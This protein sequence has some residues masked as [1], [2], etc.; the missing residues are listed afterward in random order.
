MSP[1]LGDIPK[2]HTVNLPCVI[3]IKL[4]HGNILI[5]QI[6]AVGSMLRGKATSLSA[7]RGV[8]TGLQFTPT[9]WTES[10]LIG[11]FKKED[12][13]TEG[14]YRLRPKNWH[15]ENNI[16]SIKDPTAWQN[17]PLLPQ[18]GQVVTPADIRR[19]WEGGINFVTELRDADDKCIRPGMRSPQIGALHA[20]ASHRTVSE[21]PAII[22]MPTGTGK[23]EVM[24]ACTVMLNPKRLL[25]LVPSDALRTQ[26]FNKFT[27]FGRLREFGVISSEVMNPVVALVKG[28]IRNAAELKFLESANVVVSTV[29]SL[30]GMTAIIRE[31][32]IK[33]FDHVFFDEAHHVPSNTWNNLYEDFHD[34]RIMQFTATPFRE[35]G[36]RI[37]GKIIY[38]F[39]LRMAQE[40]KY[41]RRINFKEVY[42]PDSERSDEALAEKAVEALREDISNGYQHILLA[43]TD[44]KQK[45]E[46]IVKIYQRLCP[47]F[48][49]IAIY[50]QKPG[51]AAMIREIR[52]LKHNV[53]VCVD[54][55]GEGFDL[56]NLKIAALHVP[57]S[58]LAITLQFCGRFTRDA[59][60]IGNATLVANIADARVSE[61]IEELY[62]EDSDWNELIPA[63]SAKAIE[64]QVNFSDFLE[65]MERSDKGELFDL[66]VL[67]PKTST[68][69]F[70]VKSFRPHHFRKGLTKCS[71]VTRQ[72][73]SKNKN[74]LVFITRSRIPIDWAEVKAA[75]DI[76]WDLYVLYWNESLGVLS[77]NSSVKGAFH[78][79]LAK[80]VS[81]DG[82]QLISGE[83]VFRALSGIQ[84]LVFHNAGLYRQGTKL[85]FRMYVGLD[86]GEAISPAQQIG[87]V[88]SN[89]FGVGYENG[90]RVSIG[91]SRN[92]RVWAMSSSSIPDW[93]QW[94]ENIARKITDDAI[95]TNAFLASTLI[96]QEISSLP[97]KVYFAIVFPEC[98]YAADVEDFT[99]RI[100]SERIN[101]CDLSSVA[102]KKQNPTSALWEVECLGRSNS[103]EFLLKWGPEPGAFRVC[104]TRGDTLEIRKGREVVSLAAFFE[105][106]PPTI[107]AVDGSE[108]RG[109]Q[110]LENR[111][112]GQKVF[113]VQSITVC[114]WSGVNI[115][116]ES[117]WKDGKIR[118]NSIQAFWIERLR[119]D[120]P[121]FIF[122]DD[123]AGEA[124][125]VITLDES[126]GVLSVHLYHCKFS[127]G[128]EAGARVKDCYEVCGQ[129]VKSARWVNNYLRLLDHIQK[130]ESKAS[131][132]SR[133]SRFEHGSCREF[134]NFARQAKR[135]RADFRISIVQPGISR[136]GVTP[137]ISSILGA[138]DTFI[139]DFTGH[140]MGVF[141]SA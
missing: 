118:R 54:M 97:D 60:A 45:A 42:E 88:K 40:Q 115:Q 99:I 17:H 101:F 68:V 83:P 46:E 20:I 134:T 14:R 27:S 19:S 24:L 140:E 3:G 119:L 62:A 64:S 138:A 98:F 126:A 33:L 36:K 82:A 43:R 124:A 111:G 21:K 91:A 28:H 37:P 96:P 135:M 4:Q 6:L 132:G 51:R 25:V 31:A 61:S 65:A 12:L 29:A 63:L 136:S 104:Q 110:L 30:V 59:P 125:D 39:P 129:A 41:F 78:Q 131:R 90:R 44:T 121:L 47:E 71:E 38:N 80:A 77:I 94:C 112:I 16:L 87:N 123:D 23:T 66:N 18:S 100:A 139:R 10:I 141:G 74:L 106:N 76:Q 9:G 122:D 102:I 105:I 117:K 133:G 128:A 53:I 55:F 109:A 93:Q 50:S 7:S 11:T 5:L 86:I 48:A 103:F 15:C 56:P 127:S 73:V 34:C 13:L 8:C 70:K 114:D 137:E 108:V 75:S 49:P 52:E 84:R 58:S 120:G 67:W 32:F 89:L 72:W 107:F 92:G 35:D 81:G 57:H 85:R 22:V 2:I 26:T 113:P 116:E 130:R 95:C 79:E 1:S 69:F